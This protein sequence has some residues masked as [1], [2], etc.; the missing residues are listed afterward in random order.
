MP[1]L[2]TRRASAPPAPRRRSRHA[3]GFAVFSRH[4]ADFLAPAPDAAGG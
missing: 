4:F 1:K 3:V 2:A